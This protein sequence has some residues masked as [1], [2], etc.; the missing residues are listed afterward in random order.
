[1]LLLSCLFLISL[2]L[3]P[4][5]VANRSP[6]K[7]AAIA[8][9]LLAIIFVDAAVLSVASFTPIEISDSF[10]S[11]CAGPL[12]YFDGLTATMTLLIGFI[13]CVIVNYAMRYLAGEKTQ[14]RFM[15]WLSF[16]L[17]SVATMVLAGNLVCL[18][19]AWVMT[20]F[21][22]H[23]LLTHYRDRR[24]A[25]L[26]ARKKF[27]ISRLGD[28]A[29]FAGIAMVFAQ[30]G[31]VEYSRIFE[32]AATE[33]GGSGILPVLI[34]VCFAI[35]ALTK[36][37]QFPFHTW[38]PET[39]ETPTPVSALMH[40]GII[41]GGGFLIIRLSPLIC[42]SQAA[43]VILVAVG[44]TTALLGGVV[45]MCQTSIKRKLAFSTIA[46]M[47]FMILQCGLGAF[48][49]A[50]LHIVAH[51]LYKAHAFL[52]AGSAADQPSYGLPTKSA[53]S[54]PSIMA[55]AAGL[56]MSTAIVLTT[57]AVFGL[58]HKLFE[59][60]I[61]LV[62]AFVLAMAFFIGSG[63]LAT[64][65]SAG[66]GNLLVRFASHSFMALCLSAIYA[67]A[68]KVF[69]LVHTPAHLESV[70]PALWAASSMIIAAFAAVYLMQLF[71][72]KTL[73]SQSLN[74]LYV[75]ALNGFYLDTIAHRIAAKIS[76]HDLKV[77][78]AYS[79][80]LSMAKRPARD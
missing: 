69:E 3:L 7:I 68:L 63:T 17:G 15:K 5:R 58:T 57:T 77:A 56:L 10:T 60:A 26:A 43:M 38:L 12:T 49:A 47:G 2:G 72:L 31:S 14:G 8:I 23:Q 59:P 79:S 21:G 37:A 51:S 30:F 27:L 41:N 34:G 55:H 48:S 13:G 53:S 42:L 67:G 39:M 22:L 64:S 40:A 16:T 24:P 29:I 75:H 35:G 78:P 76:G 20:S 46:Q 54:A 6:M 66:K 74:A 50:L 28:V 73:P 11:V 33:E 45:M 70:S 19:I 44:G 4:N 25:L 71:A 61:V 62:V 1:M 32:L 65:G 36:S 52:S 9:A 80:S 18:A